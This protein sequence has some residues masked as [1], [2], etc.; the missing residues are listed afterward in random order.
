MMPLPWR[1]APPEGW[2]LDLEQHCDTWDRGIGAEKVG[3]RW[4]P[5]G[6]AAV[7]CSLDPATATLE[8]AVHKGFDA[9]DR[10]AHVMTRVRVLALADIHVVEP[11]EVPN[12]NWLRPGW[13]SPAQQAFGRELLERHP[14][15]VIPSVVSSRSWNLLFNPRRA[16]GRYE[17]VSQE[18]FA[19]DTRL[20]PGR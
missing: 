6:Y 13:P 3:G 18:R 16:A 9:L 15:V 8:V 1:P 4:N 5:P 11:G 19:L 7:Y 2:R 10:I 20:S 17:I 14:F 12:P